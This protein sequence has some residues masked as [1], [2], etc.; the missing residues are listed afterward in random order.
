MPARDD[1]G[2]AKRSIASQ[3]AAFFPQRTTMRRKRLVQEYVRSDYL[4]G[5][6]RHWGH[7]FGRGVLG[8]APS[9]S[10]PR[11]R[12][13]EP[14]RPGSPRQA[15]ARVPCRGVWAWPGWAPARGAAKVAAKSL[16]PFSGRLIGCRGVSCLLPAG[17]RPSQ[18]VFQS[19]QSTFQPAQGIFQPAQGIFQSSQSVFRPAQGIFQSSQSVFQPALARFCSERAQ[20]VV[21]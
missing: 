20:R 5:G 3:L 21:L 7:W 10:R 9:D 1:A 19:S 14:W 18:T 4:V 12:S 6:Q 16:H 11:P 13:P 17:K 8:R 15:V 2:A